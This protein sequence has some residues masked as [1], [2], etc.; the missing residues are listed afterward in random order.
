M[1]IEEIIARLKKHGIEKDEAA[2]RGWGLNEQSTP[3]EVD[4]AAH[5]YMDFVHS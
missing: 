2:I 3:E 4:M 1:T 5:E